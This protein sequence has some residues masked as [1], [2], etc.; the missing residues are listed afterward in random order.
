MYTRK[1][2]MEESGSIVYRQGTDLFSMNLVSQ[3]NI[4]ENEEAELVEVSG[5]VGKR[6]D[7]ETKRNRSS[8]EQ[9]LAG[10]A[11]KERT[12]SFCQTEIMIDEEYGEISEYRCSCEEYARSEKLCRHCVAVALSYI[13]KTEEKQDKIPESMIEP[14]TM[15]SAASETAF[16]KLLRFYDKKER[17]SVMQ[18]SWKKRIEI[19][20]QMTLGIGA[21]E[22][23][24]RIGCERKYIVKSISAFVRAVENMEKVSY[25]Q[26]LTFFHTMDCFAE[27]SVDMVR[28]LIAEMNKK[29]LRA[30]SYYSAREEGRCLHLNSSN[31]DGFMEAAI[32]SGV[33]ISTYGGKAYLWQVLKENPK[34]SLTLTGTRGGALL[35]GSLPAVMQG[36]EYVYFLGNR[37]IYQVSAKEMEEILPFVKFFAGSEKEKVEISKAEL[38]VFCRELLPILEKHCNVEKIDFEEEEYLPPQAEYQIYLDAPEKD[39]V[40]AKVYAVYGEAKY[41]IYASVSGRINRDELGEMR[42]AQAVL[43]FFDALDQEQHMLV[44]H[45]NE[46][47]L[48]RFLTEEIGQLQ[49]LGEVYISESL[50]GIDV[51]PAPKVTVGVSL[52]GD[53]LEFSL[54]SEEMPLK[55]LAEILARYDR[56][57]KYFRLKDGTF[58]DMSQGDMDTISNIQKSLQL[59]EKELAEGRILVP[60]FRA[61]YLDN[62]LKENTG[63]AAVKDK[64]FKSLIRN[65]KTVEDNDFEVPQSLKNVLR[66]YQKNG[67]LWLKTLKNNGFGGILADDMGLGKTLQVIAFLLSEKQEESGKTALIVCPASL[68]YNWKSEIERFAPELLV[69][70]ISGNNQERKEQIEAIGNEDVVITSYDLLRRD[71]EWYEKIRFGYQILDEAQYIK[72]HTTQAAKSAKEIKAGFKLA[73]TGTPIE[74]RLSELWSIFDYLMPGFLYSYNRF[75]TDFEI[76]IVQAKSENETERLKKMI[77]PFILRRLKK[78]VLK[79]LPEKLEEN[80]IVKFSKEQEELY[81]AHVGRLKALLDNQTGEEFAKGK[82]QI[83][84][85]LTR[86][87]QICCEPSLVYENYVGES[88][89]LQAC[90]EMLKNAVEGGHKVLV[91]SQ[92]TTMLTHLQKQMRKEDIPYFSLIGSTVKENRAKMVEK[93]NSGEVPVFFISL[94]AGGT[95][96]NLTAADIVIHYD[97]WW[98]VAVQNQATDRA[99]RIGQKNVVTVYKLIAKDTIEEKIVKLQERKKELAEQL[100][101]GEGAGLAGMTKEEL[102]ELLE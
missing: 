48:Y 34:W 56:K 69:T 44:L 11:K 82:V 85:E 71:I 80:M 22:V 29:S 25:G 89:K 38:P 59:T 92:F 96:L 66:E 61:L 46:D 7:E 8:M 75:R 40:T 10:I 35:E 53:L 33:E 93:F 78:D 70:M 32:K 6:A 73:L 9:E 26:K 31:M 54:D 16:S 51:K 23:E 67:F 1:K 86:L 4:V 24:F 101:D 19:I 55:Q 60:K 57:K 74:N 2:L 99:H 21:P 17:L 100:L 63:L 42:T 41:N 12:G 95:G 90:V 47:R 91:F 28:F 27:N 3:V 43:E 49:N 5:I 64:N 37:I 88:A 72:N 20:P 79:D 94:K 45:A 84:S 76:P 68:L 18:Q 102:M 97:P 15:V 87:R 98:N 50:R 65:M 81:K 13:K 30:S 52:S 14:R 39:T 36:T 83:L 62:E 58:I 77:R